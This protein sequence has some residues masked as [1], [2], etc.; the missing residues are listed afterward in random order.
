[1]FYYNLLY[2][3]HVFC[4]VGQSGIMTNNIH[5]GHTHGGSVGRCNLIIFL[6]FYLC[7][8]IPDLKPTSEKS[9]P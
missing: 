6:D 7:I 4:Q 9:G 2:I 8:T 1:M 5:G 3:K